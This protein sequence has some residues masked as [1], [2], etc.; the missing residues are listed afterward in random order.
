MRSCPARAWECVSGGVILLG[1]IVG[2]ATGM[3]LDQFASVQLFNPIRRGRRV[4]G[5]TVCPTACPRRRRTV[6]SCRERGRR[7][8]QVMLDQ[9]RWQ[10]RRVVD[11]RWLQESAARRRGTIRVWAG[12]GFDYG[13]LWWLLNDRSRRRHR[14][15]GRCARAVDFRLRRSGSSWSVIHRR[16]R[17]QPV[18]G[19]REFPVLSRAACR[20]GL[21]TC[22]GAEGGVRRQPRPI[23][24]IGSNRPSLLP[25]GG[26][27]PRRRATAIVAA[28]VARPRRAQRP[29]KTVR[30]ER[31]LR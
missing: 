21:R 22:A 30:R 6:S 10:G 23:A 3:P 31:Q 18:D 17:R 24:I 28:G 20:F 11:S 5:S 7:S 8:R 16:E 2:V 27:R 19:G 9:G 12:H 29:A 26:D 15:G 14:S 1:G 13:V 4:I 25:F